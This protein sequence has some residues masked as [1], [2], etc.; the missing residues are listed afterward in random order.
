MITRETIFLI[1]LRQAYLLS[2]WNSSKISSRTVLFTSVPKHYCSKDKIKNLFDEVKT[3]WLVEDFKELEDMIEKM[4]KAALKLEAAEITLIKNANAQRLKMLKDPKV[5]IDEHDTDHWLAVTRRPKHR[6]DKL[7]FIWGN[8]FDTISHCQEELRKQIPAVKTAQR[9]R[10]DGQAKLLGAVFVEFETQSAAQ[11]AFTMVSFNHPERIV[12]RQVG[13]HPNEV[14]WRNLRM[15]DWEALGRKLLAFAFV[16]ILTIFW[17]IPVAF[18]G[19]ISNVTYLSEKF[20]W[21]HW[22]QRL[23]SE[24]IGVLTGLVPA[25]LLSFIQSL[26]PRFYR[27]KFQFSWEIPVR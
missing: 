25:L 14:I 22:L 23:N 3:V 26:V 10:L 4:D 19:T 17:G 20:K 27:C 16:A 11:A 24:Q 1:H 2:P 7:N 9:L 5:N 13:V 18:I 8:R 6:H 21:L 12:P 15:S